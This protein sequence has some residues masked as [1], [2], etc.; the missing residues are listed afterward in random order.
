MSWNSDDE[1]SW[2]NDGVIGVYDYVILSAIKNLSTFLAYSYAVT[3]KK[4]VLIRPILA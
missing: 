4:V 2:L 3:Q 1:K